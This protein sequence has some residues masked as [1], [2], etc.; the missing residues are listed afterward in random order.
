MRRSY[1]DGPRRLPTPRGVLRR[2]RLAPVLIALPLVALLWLTIGLPIFAEL[3]GTSGGGGALQDVFFD[4]EASAAPGGGGGNE[5]QTIAAAVVDP[6]VVRELR[7]EQQ[8]KQLIDHHVARHPRRH[9][10]RS[11]GSLTD[12]RVQLNSPTSPLSTPPPAPLTPPPPS[13][14]GPPPAPTPPPAP[15]PPPSPTPAPPPPPAPPAPPVSPPPPAPP[16]PPPAP[17]PPPPPP[18]V[19]PTP[20]DVDTVDNGQ[21]GR[22]ET[23][24]EVVFTFSAAVDPVSIVAGWDGSAT[25][26][27]VRIADAGGTSV[28]TVRDAANTA[29]IAELGS[30]RTNGDYASAADFTS[31]QMTLSGSTITI[32]LGTLLGTTNRDP[33]AKTMVWTTPHGT[34]TESGHPDSNF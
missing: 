22:P 3:S 7:L 33:S 10:T 1:I 31:S 27:V 9:R 23:G 19:T 2:T 17:P 34:A 25:P 11:H 16:P 12:Q 20:A 30:V 13:N 8:Q 29:D 18:P 28:L 14:A 21:F 32:V 15:A 4:T 26:V 6:R 24:D 5:P